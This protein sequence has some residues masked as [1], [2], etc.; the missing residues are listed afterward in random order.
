[1]ATQFS[2]LPYD[3]VLRIAGQVNK[4]ARSINKL[5]CKAYDSVVEKM[6]VSI[7]RVDLDFT[8]FEN[9]KDL[10]LHAMRVN[11]GDFA[12]F[13]VLPKLTSLKIYIW[14]GDFGT[15]YLA[16]SISNLPSL[17]SL[18]LRGTSLQA[19]DVLCHALCELRSLRSLDIGHNT[20]LG[21]Q[22]IKKLSPCF[23]RLEVLDIS[24]CMEAGACQCI[25]EIA[26]S[27]KWI[28]VLNLENNH[29][30]NDYG[31]FASFAASL[32]QVPYLK[33]LNLRRND[34][35]DD[36]IIVIQPFV[37]KVETINIGK[38]FLS[39]ASFNGIMQI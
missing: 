25:V 7:R 21:V 2:D 32:E 29:I 11:E 39:L 24:H 8:R 23:G 36:D 15:R 34:L 16:S 9:L 17:E 28:R 38:N 6:V 3:V 13:K 22:G 33:E 5:M 27:L 19:V 31:T 10:T 1:M 14:M 12:F 18:T 26:S 4:G 30:G 37:K 35:S 20:S